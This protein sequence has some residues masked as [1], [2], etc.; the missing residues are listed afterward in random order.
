[1]KRLATGI[2]EYEIY[3]SGSSVDYE[4]SYSIPSEFNVIYVL[5]RTNATSFIAR[6]NISVA[7]QEYVIVFGVIGLA[8][9]ASMIPSDIS[10]SE[11]I[12]LGKY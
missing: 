6:L 1:M 8:S 9:N 3:W 10:I 11:Q 4:I 2:A 12:Q 7:L 5:G